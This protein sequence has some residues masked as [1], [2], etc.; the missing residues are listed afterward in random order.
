MG[1]R[2]LFV[3]VGSVFVV[4]A[5]VFFAIVKDPVRGRFAFNFVPLKSDPKDLMMTYVKVLSVPCVRW[6]LAGLFFKN[7]ATTANVTFSSKYFNEFG[8]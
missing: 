4:L 6:G 2:L 1:W 5:G 8:D 3:I 7:Y